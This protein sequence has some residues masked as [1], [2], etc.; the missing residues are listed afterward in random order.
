MIASN[1]NSEHTPITSCVNYL[2]TVD[3]S[4]LAQNS[5]TLCY[6]NSDIN[7]GRHHSGCLLPWHRVIRYVVKK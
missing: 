5:I 3:G 6:F 7:D 4:V 1:A 2:R